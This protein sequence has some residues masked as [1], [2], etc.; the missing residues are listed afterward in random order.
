MMYDPQA[1]L[2]RQRQEELRSLAVEIAQGRRA[3][4]CAR[5]L[6]WRPLHLRLVALLFGPR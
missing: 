1:V 6:A 4:E 2:V 5:P 3:R